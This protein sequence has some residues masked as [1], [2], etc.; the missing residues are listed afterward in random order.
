MSVRV[1]RCYADLYDP[2]R[3]LMP[4][5]VGEEHYPGEG[6]NFSNL[7]DQVRSGDL[8]KIKDHVL[9][10]WHLPQTPEKGVEFMVL[11]D[12]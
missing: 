1:Y 12:D 7:G 11:R 6:F 4:I 8:D 10:N 5:F 3:V 2:K 9:R